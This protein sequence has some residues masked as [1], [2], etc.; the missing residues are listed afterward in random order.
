MSLL[1]SNPINEKIMEEEIKIDKIGYRV[2][3]IN[4]LKQGTYFTNQF[5]C[6][7]LC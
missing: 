2:R 6:K 4:K 1:L 3:I 5:R 7:T